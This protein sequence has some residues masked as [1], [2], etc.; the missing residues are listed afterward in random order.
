M[1]SFIAAMQS[2]RN[3]PSIHQQ[4][5]STEGLRAL[6]GLPS[7]HQQSNIGMDRV[8]NTR[9]V[10][11]QAANN[12]LPVDHGLS[13]TLLNLLQQSENMVSTQ[14]R[15]SETDALAAEIRMLQQHAGGGQSENV[16]QRLM[17]LINPVPV[18]RQ[19]HQ[20]S[21]GGGFSSLLTQ[22]E[23]MTN[24]IQ[25]NTAR[26]ST[27]E[28]SALLPSE[29]SAELPLPEMPTLAADGFPVDLPAVLFTSADIQRLSPHQIFLRQQIEAFRASESDIGTHKR[30]RNKPI[31][32]NQVGIRCRHCA[33]IPVEKRQKGSTYFPASCS[34]IYQASQNMNTMHLQCGLCSEMPEEVRHR[35]SFLLAVK[36]VSLGAGRPYW[37]KAAKD[38]GLVDTPDGIRFFRDDLSP[39][40]GDIS[41]GKQI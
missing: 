40:A 39:G 33:H 3:W 29:G 38:I 11:G 8:D 18:A 6:F 26:F 20:I 34:G 13:Q 15:L 31:I 1:S 28:V 23:S 4:Q 25:A 35:F 22:D 41:G 5:N 9:I 7:Q 24:I 37:E 14:P 16:M 21:V 36:G 17:N 27:P 10:S 32:L 12:S 2:S 30:G 19:D